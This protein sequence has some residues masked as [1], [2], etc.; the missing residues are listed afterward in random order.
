MPNLPLFFPSF[1]P[2]GSRP[3][4]PPPDASPLASLRV[5][6]CLFAPRPC[7]CPLPRVAS[8]GQGAQASLTRMTSSGVVHAPSLHRMC[9]YICSLVAQHL[10]CPEGP[11]VVARPATSQQVYLLC[12]ASAT[13]A[14]T[15][16]FV[17]GVVS[18]VC[19]V[20]SRCKRNHRTA[21]P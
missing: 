14:A 11:S 7:A 21:K 5:A 9:I 3:F 19:S 17:C 2:Q 12:M 8:G 1:L 20:A 16:L 13:A 4:R 15:W 18:C 10:H 6:C